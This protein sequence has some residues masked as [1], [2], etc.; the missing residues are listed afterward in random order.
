M[1]Q[2]IQ[3][4]LLFLAAILNVCFIFTPL[5]DRAL[6]DPTA[7]ISSGLF[8]ALLLSAAVSLFSIFLYKNRPFQIRWIRRGMIFQVLGI[9]FATGIIFTLGGFGSFLLDE[10]IS[11]VLIIIVLLLQYAAV[12]FISKDDKLV[13]S[14]DRIR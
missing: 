12:H 3:T 4:V 11:L 13:K 9:G 10:A 7:W 5:Y 6:E 1:I 8:S 14:M 2:R